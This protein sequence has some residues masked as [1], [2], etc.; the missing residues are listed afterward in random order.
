[1]IDDK[2]NLNVDD[3]VRPGIQYLS[4]IKQVNCNV[5]ELGNKEKSGVSQNWNNILPPPYLIAMDTYIHYAFY[6]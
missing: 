1:M 4:L 3:P 6:A 2:L 5:G